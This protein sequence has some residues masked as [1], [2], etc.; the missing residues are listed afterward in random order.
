[1]KFL[2]NKAILVL[3]LSDSLHGVNRQLAKK[4]TVIGQNCNNFTINRQKLNVFTFT[5]QK[6]NIHVFTFNLQK[7][8][9]LSSTIKNAIFLPSTVIWT[10]QIS[11]QMHQISLIKRLTGGKLF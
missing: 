7:R 1:L 5:C 11:H 8:L 3:A 2:E 4:L 9:F 6:R 10:R